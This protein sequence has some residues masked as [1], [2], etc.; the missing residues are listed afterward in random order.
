MNDY[1]YAY[2]LKIQ[3]A[4]TRLELDRLEQSAC[5]VYDAGLLTENELGR[6]AVRIMER[7]AEIEQ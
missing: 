4:T 5:R 2:R 6:L 7:N 1:E 3:S